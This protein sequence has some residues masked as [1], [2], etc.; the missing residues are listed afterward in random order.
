MDTWKSW[1]IVLVGGGA[2]WYYY[3][4][5]DKSK[6]RPARPSSS[7]RETNNHREREK[8]RTKRAQKGKKKERHAPAADPITV[9]QSEEIS[10]GHEAADEE[11][12][13]QE[14]AQSLN[15]LKSGSFLAAAAQVPKAQRSSRSHR[16]SPKLAVPAEA[17][18]HTSSSHKSS[19]NSSTNGGDADDDFSSTGSPAPGGIAEGSYSGSQNVSDM[20]ESPAPGPSILRLTEPIQPPRPVKTVHKTPQVQ[21]TKKQRQN[22]RKAEE[23]K[24]SR[25]EDEKERRILLEKQLKTAR[26]AEGRPAK[27]GVVQPRPP[28]DPAWVSNGRPNAGGYAAARSTLPFGDAPL[29]DTFERETRAPA[30]K[31]AVQEWERDLPSEEEQLRILNQMDENSGWNTVPT[32]GKKGKKRSTGNNNSTE[33]SEPEASLL[34]TLSLAP[35]VWGVPNDAA[36][37]KASTNAT[38]PDWA[39]V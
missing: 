14:F 19:A 15:R 7:A 31:T 17:G 21:E 28:V 24:A 11:L 1:G 35:G 16:T 18:D 38:D 36:S 25:Q 20:L 23:K 33:S 26:E 6:T 3:S 8:E 5:K 39:V 27:N 4:Q 29:L 22:R 37:G 2:A 9:G 12:N 10:A 13:N 34:P 32:G 30:Q